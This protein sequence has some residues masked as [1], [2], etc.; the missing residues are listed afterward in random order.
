[1]KIHENNTEAW[2]ITLID[3]GENTLTGGRLK[4]IAKYIKNEDFCFTYGDGLSNVNLKELINFHRSKGGLATLTGVQ[5]PGRFGAL[6]LK[7][8]EVIGF[9]EKPIGD[10]GWINGGFF[11]LSHKIFD[12]IEGDQTI[13]EKEPIENL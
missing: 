9:E 7:H 13:W 12:Y 3:T 4:R 1:M 10:G 5:P 2:N 8:E 11:V 6:N